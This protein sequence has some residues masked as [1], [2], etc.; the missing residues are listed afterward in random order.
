MNKLFVLT[1]YIL[2]ILSVSALVNSCNSDNTI[3]KTNKEHTFETDFN[4]KLFGAHR[5][6]K[7]YP[8]N[9][10]LAVEKAIEAGYNLVEI[11]VCITKKQE[12][13]EF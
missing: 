13:K 3:A 4:K 2:I 10:Y 7:G 12:I 6:L 11:D 5:G 1:I 8:E 9:T